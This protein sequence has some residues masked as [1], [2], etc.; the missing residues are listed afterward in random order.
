MAEPA[1]DEKMAQV[2]Q[3]KAAHEAQ[4]QKEAEQLDN[5][6]AAL[7]GKRVA[8]AARATEK[9]G[10]FKSITA[11]DIVKAI[12]V[13]HSL[14]IP[15]ENIYL[16]EHIKTVGEHPVLLKSKNQKAELV[17]AITAQ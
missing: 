3:A 12:R 13:E 15:E 4:L 1:T 11:V 9:G 6:I 8:I 14:E 7:R 17:V 5:K 16:P 2:E 10:L